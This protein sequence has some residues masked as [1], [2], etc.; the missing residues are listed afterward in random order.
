MKY[1]YKKLVAF[2]LAIVCMVNIVPFTTVSENQF[3]E[4]DMSNVVDTEIKERREE[5]VKHFRREDGTAE[6]IVY[7]YAVHRKDENGVW[8]DIDNRLTTKIQNGMTVYSTKDERIKFAKHAT[9]ESLI[10]LSENGYQISMGFIP[11]Q[12]G[13]ND[14]L[15]STTSGQIAVSEAIISNHQS[16]QNQ[17]TNISQISD[18]TDRLERLKTIDNETSVTYQNVLSDISLKYLLQSNE[19]KEYIVVNSPQEHYTYHFTLALS[20]LQAELLIDGSI[21]LTDVDSNDV[22][23]Y[24][25]APYMIDSNGNKSTDVYYALELLKEN[26]YILTVT[27]NSEWCNDLSRKYPI[28][29]DPTIKHN[30]NTDTYITGTYPTLTPYSSKEL[31]IGTN[32]ITYIKPRITTIPQGSTVTFANLNVAYYYHTNVTSGTLNVGVY[33]VLQ[34]WGNSLTW[35][36]ASQM[37]NY[38]LSTTRLS[39]KTLRGDAGAY[40]SSPK[41]ITFIVTNAVNSWFNGTA[42]NGVALRRESGTLNDV[43]LYSANSGITYQPYFNIN[44]TEPVLYEGVYRLRSLYNGLYLTVAGENDTSGAPVQQSDKVEMVNGV[45]NRAQLFKI[46]YIQKYGNMQYYNIRPMT[47]SALGL[48]A[49]ISGTERFVTANTMSTTDDWF[50]IP[51]TQRWTIQT[52]ATDGYVTIQNAFSDNGGYLS[53][54]DNLTSGE[55]VTAI[56]TEDDYCRWVLEPYTGASFD[57]AVLDTHTYFLNCGDTFDFDAHM[58]SSE[59]GVNGPVTYSVTNVDGSTTDKATI[60]ATT[61]VLTALK[62]GAVKVDFTYSNASYVWRWYVT[63]KTSDCAYVHLDIIYDQAYLIRYP[64]AFDKI[65]Y[66]AY[67][68]QDTYLEEFNIW[69]DFDYPSIFN[70]HM[71]TNCSTSPEHICDHTDNSNC[72]NSTAG[73]VK[74]L[75]HNNLYNIFHHIPRPDVTKTFRIAFTGHTT[76]AIINEVHKDNSMYGLALRSGGYMIVANFKSAEDELKT[77][78][79]EFGHMYAVK[80]HYGGNVSTTDDMN[81]QVGY[82]LYSRFCIYGEKKGTPE[83]LSNLTICDGCRATIENNRNMYDHSTEP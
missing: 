14:T 18:E 76:C 69:I 66:Y 71:D 33:Q 62:P 9:D 50:D 34:P 46:S 26:M 37:T 49:P 72:Q 51:E 82:E 7:G 74:E 2:L 81:A 59:I 16:R 45:L 13:S 44:Y 73:T 68:L 30:W 64:D 31:W 20:G 67:I 70:S 21:E 6:A 58:Y 53:V 10:T 43:I 4:T 54:P 24:I 75:H 36:S 60:D 65:L 17:L 3:S 15:I 5:N 25:P 41:W 32:K 48:Y 8:Q 77:F 78:M 28:M 57:S 23:Y 1:C 80:D 39:Y 35:D 38:G 40:S 11:S 12:N 47:N 29:I 61:G 56:T 19:I 63:I 42:N 52:N 22:V 83:V 55:P 79:H 27:A